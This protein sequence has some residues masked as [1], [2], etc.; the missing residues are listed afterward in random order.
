MSE[1]ITF[2]VEFVGGRTVDME[3]GTDAAESLRELLPKATTILGCADCGDLCPVTG[4]APRREMPPCARCD[5][6]MSGV[7]T[8]RELDSETSDHE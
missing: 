2:R 6:P 1:T 7:T 5:E 3:F 8:V 4:G